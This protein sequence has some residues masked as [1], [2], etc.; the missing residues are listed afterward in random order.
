MLKNNNKIAWVEKDEVHKIAPKLKFEYTAEGIKEGIVIKG[1]YDA[2]EEHLLEQNFELTDGSL[3]LVS[4]KERGAVMTLRYG[5]MVIILTKRNNYHV[6]KIGMFYKWI[7]RS[8]MN[9]LDKLSFALNYFDKTKFDATGK[10]VEECVKARE[11]IKE[12]VDKMRIA[13]VK[14]LRQLL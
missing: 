10:P 11:Y 9:D 8:A 1:Y 2:L 7:N 6:S 14:N 4:A 3:E 13:G 12:Y 5:C